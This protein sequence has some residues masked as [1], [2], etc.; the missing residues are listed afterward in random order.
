MQIRNNWNNTME[1]VRVN[2]TKYTSN[3]NL[4]IQLWCD[5]GP[6]ALLTV[7]LNEKLPFNRAYVDTNN[8]PTAKE[9]I[10]ENNLGKEIGVKVSGYCA[11]PLYEFN[12]ERLTTTG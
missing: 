1:E 3:D 10:E 7:N 6:Y 4:A 11:Y 5:E 9:F 8:L 12:M 2:I